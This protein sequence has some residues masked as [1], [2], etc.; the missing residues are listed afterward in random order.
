MHFRI[1][2]N[3]KVAK[4][5]NLKME[6]VRANIACMTAV[7]FSSAFWFILVALYAKENGKTQWGPRHSL[8]IP[9]C[10]LPTLSSVCFQENP[11][12]NPVSHSF[13]RGHVPK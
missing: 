5:S 10:W 2:R 12:P 1:E 3:I 11:V 9:R 6:N 7:N 13:C 4:S 8:L